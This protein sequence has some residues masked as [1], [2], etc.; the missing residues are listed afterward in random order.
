VTRSI[1]DIPLSQPTP[2]TALVVAA[3]LIGLLSLTGCLPG[4]VDI[5]PDA[6]RQEAATDSAD[7]EPSS[8]PAPVLAR[9]SIPRRG[10]LDG[11]LR[12][13]DLSAEERAM[14][15]AELEGMVDLRRLSPRTGVSITRTPSGRLA[16]VA[17]RAEQ[18][19]FVR[20]RLGED[21]EAS[22]EIVDLSVRTHV[23]TAGGVVESSVAQAFSRHGFARELTPAF[24]DIFQWDV[25]L[26]VD[27]RPGD[28]V[29]VVYEVRSVGEVPADT[30]AFAGVVPVTGD[31]VGLGRILAATYDGE[32]AA[33]EAFWVPDGEGGGHYYDR[34]GNPLRKT[35]L[36][37]PLN[38][39][40]ISSGFTHARRHPITRK[41]VPHH[42]VDFAAPSGT[43]VVAAADGR[44]VS[45]GWS[46]SL[47]KTVKIRHGSEYT[48]VYGH[49]RGYA[50]G[51]RSGV[52]VEQGRVV[53]YVGAT[54]RA[55][56]PHLH[57]SMIRSGRPINPMRFRN[58]PVESL[59]ESM[60]PRL[61]RALAEWSPV[62]GAIGPDDPSSRIAR[63][64]VISLFPG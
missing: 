29:R 5:E 3:G 59:P 16:S 64:G 50:R 6:V 15:V 8:E 13:L 53:G 56:G 62:L 12:E 11:L 57:Y 18:D 22:G 28:E 7:V 33:A 54:G 46:G 26:L 40:R 58:P 43:P 14:V 25:D 39:R 51:I 1:E 37:S 9:G 42:G 63:L 30:P 45:V 34:D 44:V 17:C 20:I 24:A 55:T 21:G 10:T 4:G 2:P 41:V 49:L 19:R 31:L 48:T 38:Y 61:V 52:S 60:R 47:G 32:R 35:F 36:K 27:P 23:E